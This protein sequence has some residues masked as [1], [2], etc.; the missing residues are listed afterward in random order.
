MKWLCAVLFSAL[1]ATGIASAAP[2]QPVSPELQKAADCMFSILKNEPGFENAKLGVYES[3][4]FSLPYLQ[5]LSPLDSRGRRITV[6]FGAEVNCAAVKRSYNCCPEKIRFCFVAV[7][8]GIF[9]PPDPGPPDGDVE[10]IAKKWNAQ[11]NVN[12]FGLLV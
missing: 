8:N 9:A 5:Y 6:S 12:A 1:L 7:L 10:V 11:C 3:D 2:A 4:G